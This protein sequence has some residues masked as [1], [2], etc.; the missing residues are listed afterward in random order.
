MTHLRACALVVLP[1]AVATTAL[2]AGPALA[3]DGEVRRSGSCSAASDWK[4]KAAHDDGRLEVEF[5]VDS[6][7]VGQS[8]TWRLVDNGVRVASGTATT[9]APSGSFEVNRRIADRAG[10][11]AVRFRATNSRSGEVCTG[12]VRL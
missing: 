4:L 8:W 2:S 12:L 6:N 5:E 3:K 11:D 1:L 9:T 7:V 10:T